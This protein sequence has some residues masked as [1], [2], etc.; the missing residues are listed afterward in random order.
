[1]A[2]A[3][4]TTS[5]VVAGRL[6]AVALAAL[7]LVCACAGQPQWHAAKAATRDVPAIRRPGRP[8]GRAL[9]TMRRHGNVRDTAV[10]VGGGGS[11]PDRAGLASDHPA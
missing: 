1:M 5:P 11:R 10:L 9:A 4:R 2:S 7:G 8:V 6:I 3:A